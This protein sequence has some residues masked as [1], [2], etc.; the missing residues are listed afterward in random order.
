MKN[1][2]SY[3]KGTKKIEDRERQEKRDPDQREN[4]NE[5]E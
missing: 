5:G 4:T 2:K 1:K 3:K